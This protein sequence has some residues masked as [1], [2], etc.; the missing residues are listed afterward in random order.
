MPKLGEDDVKLS[1][2]TL[3]IEELS[4]TSKTLVTFNDL[5]LYL[6]CKRKIFLTIVY[7][8]GNL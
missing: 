6:A 5:G 8:S 1:K 4:L 2:R 7:T 3:V